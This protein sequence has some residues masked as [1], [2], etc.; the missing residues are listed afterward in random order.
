MPYQIEYMRVTRNNLIQQ[1]IVFALLIL[2]S[3]LIFD[4]IAVS[5]WLMVHVISRILF[6]FSLDKKIKLFVNTP[7]YV[8]FLVGLYSS[9]FFFLSDISITLAM[10]LIVVIGMF[11]LDIL[12]LI[13]QIRIP[14]YGKD[15]KYFIEDKEKYARKVIKKIFLAFAVLVFILGVLWIIITIWKNGFFE[16]IE[17]PYFS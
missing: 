15:G 4:S 1:S 8:L 11:I 10:N 3:G 14:P 12:G 17:Y 13:Y 7:I 9:V 5:V 6:E 2:I 16:T